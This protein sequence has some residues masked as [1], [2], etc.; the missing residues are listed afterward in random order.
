E[1]G[2][3]AGAWTADVSDAGRLAV[4]RDEVVARWGSVDLLLNV[5]GGNVAAATLPEE[6]SPFDL[7]LQAFRDVVEL[8]LAGAVTATAA[9]GPALAASPRGNRAIVN[10]SSMAALRAITR[11]GGYGAAKAGVESFTR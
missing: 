11:V 8:N 5:A 1:A 2:V 9:F 3:D 6:A 4:V 10:V 7:D